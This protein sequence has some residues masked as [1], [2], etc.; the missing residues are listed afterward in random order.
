MAQLAAWSIPKPKVRSSNR[1]VV[2]FFF[3]TFIFPFACLYIY[4]DI[5]CVRE[6]C[7]QRVL[8]LINDFD[9]WFLLRLGFVSY[10]ITTIA[11]V[12]LLFLLPCVLVF[13]SLYYAFLGFE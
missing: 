12:W 11:R 1:V 10:L 4:A 8:H 13:L 7:M 6:N 9:Y 3:R 5:S 2:G